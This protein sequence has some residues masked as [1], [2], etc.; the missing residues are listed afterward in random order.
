[1]EYNGD[2]EVIYMEKY[3]IRRA[4]PADL[5]N[6]LT[7]Y[8]GARDFMVQAGNPTQWKDGYPARDLLMSDLEG[9]QLYVAE[10][11]TGLHGVFFFAVME[12]PTYLYMEDGTWR[13][14]TPYGVIHRIA[15]DGSG[16]I[17]S[18]CLDFCTR[19]IHHIRIDTHHD[20]QP[21]QHVLEKHGFSRRGIIYVADGTSRIAFDR[22]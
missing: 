17:F 7:I 11:A 21:M 2:N 3:K 10:N 15:S 13:S 1:M 5:E 14:D 6:I 9:E 8:A 22:V 4:V 16:G 18:A 19:Q 20:N 12:D